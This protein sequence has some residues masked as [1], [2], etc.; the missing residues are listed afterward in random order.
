MRSCSCSNL[1]LDG[2]Q[3]FTQRDALLLACVS[4]RPS[5]SSARARCWSVSLPV[6]SMLSTLRGPWRT[7]G[8]RSSSSARVCVAA[9]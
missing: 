1:L 7:C 4:L 9:L 8:S 5:I 6:R 3:F 2:P